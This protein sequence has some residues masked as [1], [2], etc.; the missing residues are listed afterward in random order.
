MCD[1][2]YEQSSPIFCKIN[3]RAIICSSGAE[4]FQRYVEKF[5]K[6]CRLARNLQRP[7]RQFSDV[8][9]GQTFPTRQSPESFQQLHSYPK[10]RIK[11]FRQMQLCIKCMKN[12]KKMYMKIKIKK[13]Y[14]EKVKNL[15]NAVPYSVLW[16]QVGRS[17]LVVP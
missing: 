17:Q 2:S 3:K 15:T 16:P 1:T 9:P 7:G 5:E 11:T 13:M 4:T 10:Y 12:Y 14:A 6:L 8:Y